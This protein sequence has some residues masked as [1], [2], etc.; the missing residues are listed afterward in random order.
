MP[1]ACHRPPNVDVFV[2]LTVP[3]NYLL[4]EV[5]EDTLFKDIV[6]REPV[7]PMDDLIK[8]VSV[9]EVEGMD[10]RVSLSSDDS[11]IIHDE[12][13]KKGIPR[14]VDIVIA[15]IFV[16]SFVR[17]FVRSF[18]VLL[19]FLHDFP[20]RSDRCTMNTARSPA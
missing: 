9:S 17:L 10:D 20:A 6:S 11:M 3:T 15:S 8:K 7:V 1:D 2:T 18:D 19:A 16:R 14:H 5:V 13:P 12:K 4:T